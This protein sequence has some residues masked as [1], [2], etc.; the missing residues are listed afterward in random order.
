MASP[1]LC[2][3]F[4]LGASILVLLVLLFI[5]TSHELLDI[6]GFS[7][8]EPQQLVQLFVLVLVLVVVDVE[9]LGVVVVRVDVFECNSRLGDNEFRLPADD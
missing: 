5:D 7:L 8:D 1:D 3:E 4:D 9:V 6:S 2:I